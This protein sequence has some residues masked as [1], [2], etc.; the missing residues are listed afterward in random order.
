MSSWQHRLVPK[1]LFASNLEQRRAF[2][3]RPFSKYEQPKRCFLGKSGLGQQYAPF[4]QTNLQHHTPYAAHTTNS[5]SSNDLIKA[6]VISTRF[7]QSSADSIET[8]A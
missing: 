7:R 6:S 2:H 4:G 8:G 1:S 5:F 3:H